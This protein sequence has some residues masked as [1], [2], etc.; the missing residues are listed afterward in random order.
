MLILRLLRC[1]VV[2]ILL[3]TPSALRAQFAL[4]PNGVPVLRDTNINFEEGFNCVLSGG[5]SVTAWT[6]Q[7]LVGFRR[8]Y[9]EIITPEGEHIYPDDPPPLSQP[10]RQSYQATSYPSSDGGV[11]IQWVE[12]VEDGVWETHIQKLSSRGEI[13]W[14]EGGIAAARIES[15]II[16]ASIFYPSSDGG[17]FIVKYDA[18]GS[19]LRVKGFDADGRTKENWPEDGLIPDSLASVIIAPDAWGGYWYLMRDNT[20]NRITSHGERLWEEDR[21]IEL[22][23]GF[24]WWLSWKSNGPLLFVLSRGDACQFSIAIYDS[25]GERIAQDQLLDRELMGDQEVWSEWFVTADS[26]V[27][28]EYTISS[29]GGS[30]VASLV[31]PPHFV[32]FKPF[33]DVRLPWGEIGA[34]L[35]AFEDPFQFSMNVLPMPMFMLDSV[36]I[37]QNSDTFYGMN[38]EGF[39]AWGDHVIQLPEIDVWGR[40]YLASNGIT[41]AWATNPGDRTRC[42]LLGSDGSLPLGDS[43]VA[44][45]PHQRYANGHV[46]AWPNA[47]RGLNL[48]GVDALRGLVRQSVT[49]QGEVT[50]PLD[51]ELIEPTFPYIGRDFESG[52]VGDNFWIWQ[53]ISFYSGVLA[54]LNA[55]NEVV[56]TTEVQIRGQ[57]DFSNT[58]PKVASNGRDQILINASAGAYRVSLFSYNLAGERT[59]HATVDFDRITAI[60]YWPDHGW[61]MA[62]SYTGTKVFLLDDQLRPV[63]DN[64]RFTSHTV[65]AISYD[66]SSLFLTGAVCSHDARQAKGHRTTVRNGQDG[67]LIESID[68]TLLFAD[69]TWQTNWACIPGKNGAFWFV[70]NG[71]RMPLRHRVQMLGTNWRRQLGDGGLLLGASHLD[72]TDFCQVV[73]DSEGGGWIVYDVPDTV[74]V[75]HLD[76]SGRPTRNVYP[77]EGFDV[78]AGPGMGLINSTLD[79]RTGSLWIVGGQSYS[80]VHNVWNATVRVQLV[81]DEWVKVAPSVDPTPHVFDL[82]PAFPNPFNCSTTIKFVLVVDSRVTLTVYDL[83]GREISTLVNGEIKAGAHS[84]TWNAE[85]VAAGLYVVKMEAGAFSA[86]RKVILLK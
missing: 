44:I 80:Y 47:N 49:D 29:F 62:G 30:D 58:N 52:T 16:R 46:S 40:Y 83:A 70:G 66:D 45:I 86:S 3:A 34:T 54:L 9:T 33:E 71:E 60:G 1:I 11:F 12:R 79:P 78:Y 67:G 57:G 55:D 2:A 48:I 19:N 63:W 65:Q 20:M 53:Q 18:Q 32:C 50:V 61:V 6:A 38:S 41:Q 64:P 17:C 35:R 26:S 21:A 81:S 74:R 51:G 76:H 14:A 82:T 68:S 69:S 7:D 59:G 73:C 4:P 28:I 36:L 37:I 56:F 10:D 77:R 23:A 43:A 22:P 75:L 13:L 5:E 24:D 85:G 42:W 72:R 25:S 8:A 84:L 31:E 39:E 15:V 27:Y